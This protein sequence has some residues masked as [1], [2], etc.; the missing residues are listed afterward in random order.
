MVWCVNF[1]ETQQYL[2]PDLRAFFDR[3]KLSTLPIKTLAAEFADFKKFDD[4]DACENFVLFFEPPS[5]D[6]R[7]VNQVALFSFGSRCDLDLDAWLEDKS[8]SRPNIGKKVIIPAALKWEIRDKLDQS[9]ITE[10]VLFPGLDGLSTWLK[11]WYTPKNPTA[12]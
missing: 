11:R 6:E 10:R 7:I 4:P 3:E 8:H 5:L 9:G 12:P 1:A 2:P